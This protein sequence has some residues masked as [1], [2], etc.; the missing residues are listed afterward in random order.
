VMIFLGCTLMIREAA[1]PRS[2]ALG[3]AGRV[4]RFQVEPG[5]ADMFPM[6]KRSAG[7]DRSSKARRKSSS[8][9]A[10]AREV[11]LVS[12]ICVWKKKDIRAQSIVLRLKLEAGG[13]D[14]V[15]AAP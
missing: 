13:S 10:E 5:D 4:G 15:E 12:G 3:G 1:D 8:V 6:V 2:H 14:T 9:H 7:N 11:E